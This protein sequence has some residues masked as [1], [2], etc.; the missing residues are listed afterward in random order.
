MKNETKIS[1]RTNKVIRT[2]FSMGY[3]CKQIKEHYA[4]PQNSKLNNYINVYVTSLRN[5]ETL[6]VFRD[7]KS[8]YNQT[9]TVKDSNGKVKVIF[10]TMLN[11]PKYGQEKLIL[12]GKYYNLNW[13]NVVN[14]NKVN[15]V[16]NKSDYNGRFL[17]L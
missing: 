14:L 12:D 2:L 8:C 3:N 9:T 15:H 13:D 17:L 7:R 1:L 10:S 5:T 11:Q 16:R 6:F 4:E